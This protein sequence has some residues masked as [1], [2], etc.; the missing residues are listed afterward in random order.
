M[1]PSVQDLP[2]TVRLTAP[3]GRRIAY[4]SYGDPAAPPVIVLHGTP[5]S[6]FEGVA[7]RQAATDAGLHL[8]CPDRPGYG[9]T[10]PVPG[11]GFHRWNGDF[12]T[13]LDHLGHE[14]APLVAISGGGGY[15]LSAAQT[16]PERVTKL[17]LACAAVPGA[18]RQAYAR[19]IPIVKWLDRLVRWAP[20]IARPMLAGTGIFKRMKS[21]EPHLD[22]WPLAD[23]LIM[24]EPEFQELS[25]LDTTEARRQ[26]M[27]AAMADLAGYSRPLP[28][29]L[30][31]ISVPTVFIHGEADGNVPIEVARW[32]HAQIDGA[33]LRTVPDGGHLFLLADPDPLLRELT[34]PHRGVTVVKGDGGQH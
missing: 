25:D 16:H 12:V 20:V 19:R 26:G 34:G 8:V 13:L 5:G 15:A 6:R 1:T 30:N 10:D 23:Q 14:R 17:I 27:D 18:P 9:E 32:A 22:A 3:G 2:E 11:R 33:A 24:K 7:L 31:S 4:C 29:P 28:D 21:R